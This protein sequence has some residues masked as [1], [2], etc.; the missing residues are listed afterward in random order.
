MLS[1]PPC[2]LWQGQGSHRSWAAAGCWPG[3]LW[4]LGWRGRSVNFESQA[5]ESSPTLDPFAPEICRAKENKPCG[6]CGAERSQNSQ[7][8]SALAGGAAAIR[9]AAP[10]SS[11]IKTLSLGK[12]EREALI[13]SYYICKKHKSGVQLPFYRKGSLRDKTKFSGNAPLREPR[14]GALTGRRRAGEAMPCLQ[15]Q[16]ELSPSQ[17]RHPVN[18]PQILQPT[19][20]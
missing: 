13:H 4:L 15:I 5:A 11:F 7:Q 20:Q 10:A 1:S 16:G 18:P 3:R 9:R 17:P 8:M 14:G 6:P 19:A 12:R 2:P